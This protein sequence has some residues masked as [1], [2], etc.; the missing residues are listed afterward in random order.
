MLKKGTILKINRYILL[1]SAIIT[2]FWANSADSDDSASN[3]AKLNSFTDHLWNKIATGT[4]N[5][6]ICAPSITGNLLTLAEGAE[7][8]TRNEILFTLNLNNQT[9]ANMPDFLNSLYGQPNENILVYN[10]IWVDSAIKINGEFS[11]D[12]ARQ[13]SCTIENA[14]FAK[15]PL[16]AQQLINFWLTKSSN[17][18]FPSLL[19]GQETSSTTNMLACSGCLIKCAFAQ[20]FAVTSTREDDFF[21]DSD[22][23]VQAIKDNQT[24]TNSPAESKAGLAAKNSIK[25]MIMETCFTGNIEKG[26]NFTAVKLPMKDGK[27]SLILILPDYGVSLEKCSALWQESA[28]W[29]TGWKQI[30][31]MRLPRFS[32]DYTR[33]LKKDL[34]MSGISDAFTADNANFKR[35]SQ[36]KLHL[37]GFYYTQ[38]VTLNENGL[39]QPPAL[40]NQGK[41]TADQSST[42]QFFATRPFIFL[43][44]DNDNS[45]VLTIG[46]FTRPEVLEKNKPKKEDEIIPEKF[47]YGP[48]KF[49]MSM[50]EVRQIG[51]PGPYRPTADGGLK[52]LHAPWK[53]FYDRRAELFFDA[54]PQLTQIRLWLCSDTTE[55]KAKSYASAAEDYLVKLNGKSEEGIARRIF[56]KLIDKNKELPAIES[57]ETVKKPG[58]P[59]QR[60]TVMRHP[61]F[62]W[63]VYITFYPY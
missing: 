11:S 34:I 55:E 57:E 49:G 61:Q 18:V 52:C 56:I 47:G 54:T 31:H 28:D 51:K 1:F 43:L 33:N 35:I 14:P 60:L 15:D 19:K 16:K 59:R 58:Q 4:E 13:M 9:S 6:A 62:G 22:K 63:F 36:Q 25:T 26:K 7:G 45:T 3:P 40:E 53:K 27:H 17:N 12:T 5:A 8:E 48:W 20:P 21:L 32:F 41:D 24:D 46:Q 39:N 2:L 42:V 38:K 23:P 30:I 44:I 10:S 50:N 29:F 37:S